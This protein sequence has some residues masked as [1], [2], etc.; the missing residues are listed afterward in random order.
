[1]YIYLNSVHFNSNHRGALAPRISLSAPPTKLFF[2]S[3]LPPS[4]LVLGVYFLEPG[5]GNVFV[6]EISLKEMTDF[7]GLNADLLILYQ[8]QVVLWQVVK[9]ST[10]GII[11]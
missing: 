11:M 6:V 1:M 3:F 5:S 8:F 4:Y 2:L 10:S 7:W 9:R